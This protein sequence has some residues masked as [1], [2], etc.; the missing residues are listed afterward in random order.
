[1]AQTA[2]LSLLN[3]R[4]EMKNTSNILKKIKGNRLF[5][6]KMLFNRCISKCQSTNEKN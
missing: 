2:Q 4:D 3:Q 6:L 1:M 5:I